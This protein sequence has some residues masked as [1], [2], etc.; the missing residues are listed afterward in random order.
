MVDYR[1]DA[2]LGFLPGVNG[3][4]RVTL[5]PQYHFYTPQS[6]PAGKDDPYGKEFNLEVHLALYPKSNIV[7]GAALFLPDNSA[8]SLPA[9]KISNNAFSEQSGYF[10]YFMPTFNF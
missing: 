3:N 8:T 4:A 10:L 5:K 2:E 1:L 7:F 9:A 6:A